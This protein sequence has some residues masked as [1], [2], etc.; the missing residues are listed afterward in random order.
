[1]T[2]D[3]SRGYI[4]MPRSIFDNTSFA[5]EPYTEREAFLSMVADAAWKPRQVRLG[6]CTVDLQRG[7]LLASS[8]YLAARWDWPEP[9]VRRFL[10]RI[11][12][13]RAN[14]AQN[15]ARNDAQSDALI[16]AQPNPDGTVITIRNYDSFQ[17]GAERPDKINDAQSDARNDA[18]G[19]ASPNAE[20]TQK[21]EEINNNTPLKGSGTR[22]RATRISHDFE[23]SEATASWAVG[24]LGSIERVHSSVDRFR[25][26]FRQLAGDRALSLDWQVKVRNWIDDDARKLGDGSTNASDN[27]RFVDA[28]G[29]VPD[30]QWDSVLSLFAR[31]RYWTRHVKVFGPE[32]LSPGSRVPAH[33]LI[34]HGLVV[35]T[36]A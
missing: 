33:L 32:P 1:M 24:R 10:K 31:T 9:R 22:A 27:I 16:D 23:L 12:G 4:A 2:G 8:R 34:K 6:R 7:Q 18:S 15:D 20:S 30:E 26:H 17:G 29:D 11:S 3:K 25:N 13:R 21:E 28:G 5:R 14:D 36:G 19:D 35:P